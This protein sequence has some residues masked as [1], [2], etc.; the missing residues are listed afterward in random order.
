MSPLTRACV[1]VAVAVAAAAA[2]GCAEE[3]LSVTDDKSVRA[4]TGAISYYCPHAAAPKRPAPPEIIRDV[5]VL[6]AIHDAN[7]DAV[8]MEGQEEEKTMTRVLEL[9][10]RQVRWCDPRTADRMKRELE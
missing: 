8:F 9:A 2:T 6:I 7:P 5:D 4:A 1:A 10:E 3:E